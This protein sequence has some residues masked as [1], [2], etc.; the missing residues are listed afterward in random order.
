MLLRHCCRFW[1]QCCRRFRPQHRTKF[2]LFDKVN[3]KGTKDCCCR[4]RQHFCQSGNNV[5]AT[6]DFVEWTKFYDKLVRYC[7]RFWQHSR[8]LLIDKLVERCFDIVW[9][10]GMDGA[11]DAERYRLCQSIRPSLISYVNL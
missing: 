11:L 9:T 3:L 4:N 1:Q 8:M 2:R 6:F 5:Q 7:C 10:D